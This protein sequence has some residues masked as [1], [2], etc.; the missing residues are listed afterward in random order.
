MESEPGY[1]QY[2]NA[3][4]LKKCYNH[5]YCQKYV[6]QEYLAALKELLRLLR[7]YSNDDI[8]ESIKSYCNNVETFVNDFYNKHG[9]LSEQFTPDTL[10][11]ISAKHLTWSYTS[12]LLYKNTG[13]KV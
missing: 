5:L 2:N 3:H 11:P 4:Y 1:R 13:F 7:T 10:D 12:F 6:D 9:Q 8:F